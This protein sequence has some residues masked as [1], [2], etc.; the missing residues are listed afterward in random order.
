MLPIFNTLRI[1]DLGNMIV[2]I[3]TIRVAILTITTIITIITVS[4]G[5]ESVML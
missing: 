4:Y 3:S 1:V 5:E 2:K